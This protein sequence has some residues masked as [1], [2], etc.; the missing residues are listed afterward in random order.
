MQNHYYENFGKQ[1]HTVAETNIG[2]DTLNDPD[3]Q[4]DIDDEQVYY[5]PVQ[6]T[7]TRKTRKTRKT[8]KTKIE[9]TEDVLKKIILVLL[10]IELFLVTGFIITK[11]KSVKPEEQEES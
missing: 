10:I 1:S 4:D 2:S 5:P 3:E 6:K 9:K 11:K 8:H 7:K